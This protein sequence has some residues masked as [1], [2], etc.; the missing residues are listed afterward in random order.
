MITVDDDF[1]TVWG[2]RVCEISETWRKHNE[3]RKLKPGRSQ[4]SIT[5]GGSLGKTIGRHLSELKIRGPSAARPSSIVP[6]DDV[7]NFYSP[8]APGHPGYGWAGPPV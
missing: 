4:K 6:A 7:D 2:W 3:A 1:E 8:W 5:A